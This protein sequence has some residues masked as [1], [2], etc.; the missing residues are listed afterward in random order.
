MTPA[1]SL[2]MVHPSRSASAVMEQMTAGGVSQVLVVQDGRVIGLV[3]LDSL[4]QF[5]R[6]RSERGK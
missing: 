1:N 3:V 6:I 4:R 5:I 2:E